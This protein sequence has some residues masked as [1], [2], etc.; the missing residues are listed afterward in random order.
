[1]LSYTH[2]EITSI[3]NKHV[4]TVYRVCFTYLKGNMMDVEDAVQSTFIAL[5]RSGK[6]FI[7]SSHEKAWLIKVA[8]NLCKNMLLRKHRNDIVFDP[9][10]HIVLEE[11]DETK[12]ALMQIP[13]YERL[14]LYLH[15]YEGYTAKEIGEMLHKHESTVWGYLHK[16]RGILRSMLKEDM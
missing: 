6:S 4:N 10:R 14:S 9:D 1:M 8:S 3:Y 15:Y 2:D 13:E 11:K 5:M 16:G 12:E 7:S